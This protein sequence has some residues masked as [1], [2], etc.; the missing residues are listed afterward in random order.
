MPPLRLITAGGVS[1]GYV[2]EL[3]ERGIDR[4]PDDAFRAALLTGAVTVA[5]QRFEEDRLNFLYDL[6]SLGKPRTLHKGL[7]Q[8][9]A[10][11]V[12]GAA[13]QSYNF[14]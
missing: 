12:D 1:T 5:R 6:T 8:E 9:V 7:G 3:L 11:S 4:A 14:V 13:Y 10:L 2:A